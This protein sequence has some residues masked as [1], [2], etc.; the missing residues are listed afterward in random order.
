[1]NDPHRKLVMSRRGVLGAVSTGV[2][3]AGLGG[4]GL[5]V[6]PSWAKSLSGEDLKFI[7]VINYGGWDPT[8]VFGSEFSNAFIDMERDAE[9][10]TVGGLTFVD[11]E[12]RPY[13]RSFLEQHHSQTLFLNGILVS[14]IAHENCLRI[15]LTGSTAQDRSDWGAILAGCKAEGFA[16][17]QVVIGGPSFPGEFG[18]FVSD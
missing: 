6:R 2:G 13:V 3:L 14:S 1:M 12:N 7:I 8:R 9:E 17:P 5:P 4:L 18:A 16:L 11:H 15:Q 10:A